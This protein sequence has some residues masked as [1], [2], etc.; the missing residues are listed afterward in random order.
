MLGQRGEAI[1]EIASVRMSALLKDTEDGRIN[2]LKTALRMAD[3]HWERAREG[4]A[5]IIYSNEV[6]GK[7][8]SEAQVELNDDIISD[9][10]KV[11]DRIE[12]IAEKQRHLREGRLSLVL[13]GS[14]LCSDLATALLNMGHDKT[15]AHWV[16]TIAL[17]IGFIVG[18]VHKIK[19]GK[20]EELMSEKR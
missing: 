18:G 9:Y 14:L 20:K 4:F 19:K 17:S 10:N 5:K 1:V 6:L 3:E 11:I 15:N 12:K 2:D 8:F 7:T 16:Y 13:G